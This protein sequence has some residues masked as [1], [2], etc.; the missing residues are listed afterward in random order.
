MA[1]QTHARQSPGNCGCGLVGQSV[2]PGC[3]T[4][5]PPAGLLLAYQSR[6]GSTLLFP[7]PH[8]D[9]RTSA[10]IPHPGRLAL[11]FVVAFSAVTAGEQAGAAA[12]DP[13]TT[14]S[15]ARAANTVC[16]SANAQVR[17]AAGTHL[18]RRARRRSPGDRAPVGRRAPEAR[19]DR[20]PG[21]RPLLDRA[22]AGD[23]SDAEP[24]LLQPAHPSS[25]AQRYGD[26][27]EALPEER[28]SWPRSSTAI[29]RRLGPPR[30]SAPSPT[31]QRPVANRRH[32][33]S[34]AVS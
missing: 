28:T 9:R 18:E 19:R 12:H 1:A 32:S 15:W 14:A 31:R 34:R 4:P 13:P 10:S 3:G 17:E 16:A 30:R 23:P 11:T 22:P 26:G 6:R 20:T 25:P 27:D 7:P 2:G 21:G 29:A 5:A 24:D 33:R 8:Y